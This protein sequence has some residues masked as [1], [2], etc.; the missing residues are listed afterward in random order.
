[1]KGK[2]DSCTETD[3][4]FNFLKRKYSFAVS[5]RVFLGYTKTFK[6]FSSQTT[7]SVKNKNRT[8]NDGKGDQA[9]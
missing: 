7:S 4:L 5:E 2:D 8:D 3:K 1:M 9:F 6:N